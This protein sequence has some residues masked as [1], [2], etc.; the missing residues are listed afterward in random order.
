MG[1]YQ[2]YLR[3]GKTLAMHFCE[4]GG[5]IYEKGYSIHVEGIAQVAVVTDRP[6]H[7]VSFLTP[8]RPSQVARRTQH[9][10][11]DLF[12]GVEHVERMKIPASSPVVHPPTRDEPVASSPCSST[13]RPRPRKPRSCR[14][15]SPSLISLPHPL[16]RP[17]HCPVASCRLPSPVAVAHN[18]CP[19]AVATVATGRHCT[20]WPA[21]VAHC[22]CLPPLP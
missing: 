17:T 11:S 1:N 14:P 3:K 2:L 21:A 10:C 16:P 4:R 7:I 6:S 19:V 5:Y 9:T 13:C 8:H 15:C 22:P 20:L 12:D 18:S